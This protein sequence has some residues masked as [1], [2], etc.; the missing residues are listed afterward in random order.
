MRRI[1]RGEINMT[2]SE[3]LR[4][5]GS[6]IDRA[7]LSEIRLLETDEGMIVQGR[8]TQGPHAGESDT[9]QLTPEDLE[10]LLHD[11][12]SQRGKKL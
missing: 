8:L 5:I 10:G 1:K 3:V 11:A 7:N 6:Y 12:R 2:Y 9:Y 4:V